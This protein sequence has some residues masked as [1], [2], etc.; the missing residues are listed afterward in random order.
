MRQREQWK[1]GVFAR[2]R[3][4]RRLRFRRGT[5]AR[6]Q[7]A[8][9][10]GR[11]KP[12]RTQAAEKRARRNAPAWLKARRP[13]QGVRAAGAGTADI[14]SSATQRACR[15]VRHRASGGFRSSPPLNRWRH[16]HS[17]ASTEQRSR[18]SRTA[19]T[20]PRPGGRGYAMYAGGSSSDCRCHGVRFQRRGFRLLRAARLA[21]TA[22]LDQEFNAATCIGIVTSP[23]TSFEHV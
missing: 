14:R 15:R 20:R 6:E 16:L 8:A 19:R 7:V 2:A 10:Q 5:A 12:A 18:G 22:V 4:R 21:L 11:K 23:C 1:R 3:E 17:P 13:V 9:R